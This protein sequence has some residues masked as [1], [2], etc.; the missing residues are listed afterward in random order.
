MFSI[1]NNNLSDHAFFI[2]L[3]RS[4]DRL[5][6]IEQQI[7]QFD[8]KGLF[9]L[10]ALTDQLHQSSAT[11]SHFNAFSIADQEGFN[12]I[13]VFEDDF[14]F[15]EEVFIYDEKFKSTL[16]DYLPQLINHIQNI[17]WDIILL[18]FNGKKPCIPIS[19]HLS[20][21]FKSTGA[22][23]YLINKKTYQYI[24][25]NFNYYRDRLAIDDILPYLTY[26]GFNSF[27]T[28]IQIAH[29][30]KGFISTL[31]PSLGP[32][33]YS[34]W[35]LGNY[36]RS[37]W[38]FLQNTEQKN[39]ESALEN[40]YNNSKFARDYIGIINN[41]DG[42][43]QRLINFM[44]T[45]HQYSTIYTEI[46]NNYDIPELGYYLSV[47]CPYLIHKPSSRKNINGLGSNL[48]EIEL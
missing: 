41:F 37:I 8:I 43:I 15:Y 27:V 42:N 2:N 14:Q 29:H 32:T 11:K 35:I 1:Y 34:Q 31:Q 48:L 33:D 30:G 46:A 44:Q 28:N 39:L 40:L 7:K 10:E 3:P 25:N 47:E 24:L 9:R 26:F 16:Y 21:N 23:G 4:T 12:S 45:N 20:R 22:W 6:N 5:S 17:D 13:C 19:K 18:G 36:H 38:H